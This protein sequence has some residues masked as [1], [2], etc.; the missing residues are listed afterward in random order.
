MLHGV[1]CR[2]RHNSP[3]ADSVRIDCNFESDCAFRTRERAAGGPE[4]VLFRARTVIIDDGIAGDVTIRERRFD[5]SLYLGRTTNECT[6]E[7]SPL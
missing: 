1:P 3:L 5:R 6:L 2:V 4:G 7:V